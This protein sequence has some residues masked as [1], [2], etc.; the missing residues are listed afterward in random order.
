VKDDTKQNMTRALQPIQFMDAND[1]DL[2][3]VEPAS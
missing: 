3:F 1:I 2:K